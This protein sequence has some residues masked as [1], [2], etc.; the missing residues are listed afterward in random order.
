MN[1]K[2]IIYVGNVP[3]GGGFPIVI[4]SMTNTDTSDYRSTLRQIKQLFERGSQIVRVS[5]PN[6]SYLESMKKII[7]QSPCPIIADIHFDYKTAISAI[8]IGAQKIRINPGNM[9]KKH[10]EEIIKAAKAKNVPIRIGVN[11][12]SLEKS[13]LRK[14]GHPS[15]EALIE[16]LRKSVEFFEERDFTRLILSVKSSD[17]LSMI[18]TNMM[19]K[20]IFDYPMHL[21]VTE[22]GGLLRGSVKNSIGI[23]HLLMNN[24]G[25]TIRVSL[26]DSPLYEVDTAKMILRALHINSNMPDIISC[27][28]CSRTTFNVIRVQKMLEK[29]LEKSNKNIRV[30]VMGCIVNGPGE[31][32]EADLGITGSNEIGIV[33]KKNKIIFKGSKEESLKVLLKEVDEYGK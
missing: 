26:S 30:A 16:S 5:Y 10:L 4:Q 33:F 21:G 18:R 29:K 12:G 19:I 28:T 32:R 23:S 27:P 9:S 1:S 11:S 2:K 6:V 14:Y 20:R 31:A 7:D 15:D 8:E 24:V 17:V 3:I 25:D 13:I 22:A